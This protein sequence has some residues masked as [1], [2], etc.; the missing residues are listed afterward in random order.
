MQIFIVPPNFF[1]AV[2]GYPTRDNGI[3]LADHLR[4]KLAISAKS[5]VPYRP[6]R[7]VQDARQELSGPQLAVRYRDE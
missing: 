3:L 2:L 4:S 6:L 7:S 1:K 5:T